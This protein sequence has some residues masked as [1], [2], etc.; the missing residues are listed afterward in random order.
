M[1]VKLLEDAKNFANELDR[2]RVELEEGDK[3][4]DSSNT[5]VSKMREQFLRYSNELAQ[6][7]ERQ[8]QLEYKIEW[9]NHLKSPKATEGYSFI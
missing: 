6:T 4:P 5:E 1:E 7:E 9:Y 2:Q 3:F 8:Y